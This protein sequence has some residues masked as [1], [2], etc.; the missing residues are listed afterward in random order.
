LAAVSLDNNIWYLQSWDVNGMGVIKI[1]CSKCIK[2]FGGSIGDHSNHSINNLFA[3]FRKH[4]LHTNAHIRSLCRRQGLPYTNHLQS[5]APKGKSM[6][7]SH[8]KHEGLV[9]EGT[10][11]MDNVNDTI[12]EVNREKH[13]YVVGDTTSKGFKYQ[14]YWFKAI[15]CAVTS[16]NFVLLR[17]IC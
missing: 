14:T 10:E 16:S 11:I 12:E 7:L 5:V 6:I 3:N 4:H 9:Q 2:D 8:V 1:H 13:F 15:A 17:R